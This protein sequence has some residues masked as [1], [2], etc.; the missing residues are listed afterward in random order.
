MPSGPCTSSS[1]G[2]SRSPG[3][4]AYGSLWYHQ[5][6]PPGMPPVGD[7]GERAPHNLE[8]GGGLPCAGNCARGPPPHSGRGR[9]GGLGT[10][11]PSPPQ[12][13]RPRL[14]RV[15][16]SSNADDIEAVAVGAASLQGTVPTTEEW[17]HITGQDV[18][19]EKSCPRVQGEQR[20]PA[21][22]PILLEATFRQLGVD[23]AIVGSRFRGPVLSRRLEAGRTAP[24]HLPHLSTYDRRERVVNTMA[25]PQ[26]LH[27]VAVAS[28]TDPDMWRLETAVVRALW[29]PTRLSRA[30]ENVFTVVC[31]GHRVSPILHTRYER[32]LWLA[33]VARPPGVTRVVSHAFWEL[34]GRP[35]GTGPVGSALQT[36]ATL[37]W[38]P[39]DGRWCWDVP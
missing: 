35:P 30:K 33:R 34:G 13:C 12:R 25:T 11:G 18:C 17:L 24:R 36:A 1:T 3:L 28:V 4:W 19:V 23:V 38:S 10:G 32:L 20:A 5:R 39:R 14:R 7:L 2:P 27:G 29:R 31:K 22:V 15:A 6:H 21:G 8:M 26:A 9:G 37:G 16:A